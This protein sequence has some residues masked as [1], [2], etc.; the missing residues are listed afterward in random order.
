LLN[1][2]QNSDRFIGI[3]GQLAYNYGNVAEGLKEDLKRIMK[4]K[5]TID[6]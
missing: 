5:V 2:N 4:S 3:I 6:D 1:G